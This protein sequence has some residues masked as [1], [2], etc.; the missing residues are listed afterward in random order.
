MS[1]GFWPVILMVAAIVVWVIAKVMI[2]MKKSERLWREAD[3]SKLR[4]WDDDE[5]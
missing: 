4:H 2:N 5:W 1:K 3:K